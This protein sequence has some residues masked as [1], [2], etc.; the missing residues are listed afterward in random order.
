[1]NRSLRRFVVIAAAVVLVDQATKLVGELVSTGSTTGAV[2][3]VRNDELSLGVADAA[4]PVLVMLMALG[5]VLGA[6][7]VLPK[8]VAG[9]VAPWAAAA[10]LAG[11][12]SNL[13]DRA[14]LGSVRDFFAIPSFTV[15]NV[16]DVAVVVGLIA[17][18]AA[19]RRRPSPQ[20]W[21][22]VT[23]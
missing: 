18:V 13:I 7:W 16:A 19:V 11:A 4:T 9:R 17:T 8:V 20:P 10:V 1:M 2:V 23:T 21:K 15:I 12:A 5:I 22:E 3:P 14:V 6:S